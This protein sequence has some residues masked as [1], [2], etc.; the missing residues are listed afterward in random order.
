MS[1]LKH[2]WIISYHPGVT[3]W[4]REDSLLKNR[5]SKHR[6]EQIQYNNAEV[7][8]KIT[9]FFKLWCTSKKNITYFIA[10]CQSEHRNPARLSALCEM[11]YQGRASCKCVVTFQ[12]NKTKTNRELLL[13]TTHTGRC[14]TCQ[15]IQLVSLILYERVSWEVGTIHSVLTGLFE[16]VLQLERFTAK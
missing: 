2:K 8:C 11:S 12:L 10:L 6:Q 9:F 1:F 15:G 4:P 13:F 16:P 7:T 5:I 14:I 3:S